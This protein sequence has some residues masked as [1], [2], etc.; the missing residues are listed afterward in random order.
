[1]EIVM[2]QWEGKQL[3]SLQIFPANFLLCV[4]FWIFHLVPV[5]QKV[6]SAIHPLN[7]YPADKKYKNQLPYPLD[8]G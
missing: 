7:H 4:C 1:M 6:D 5:V 2:W 3:N 8:N